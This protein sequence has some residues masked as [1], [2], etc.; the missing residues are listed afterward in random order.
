MVHKQLEQHPRQR[1]VLKLKILIVQESDWIKRNP[2]QQHHLMERMVLRGHEVKVI[3]YPIDWK[4]DKGVRHRRRVIKGYHKIHEGADVEVVRPAILAVPVLIYPSLYLSHKHEIERQIK[5]FKP[6]VIVGFGVV[7]TY[8]ASKIARK[9]RIPFVYYWIDVLHKLIPERGFHPLGKYMETVAIKNSQLVLTINQKLEEYVR[10]MGAVNTKVI[11]AGIDLEEFDPNLDGT[12][13]RREY[14]I[15]DEDTVLFFMGFL[16]HFAGL[17][18]LALEFA[19]AEHPNLKLLIVGDGDA[20]SDLQKIVEEN[21]LEDRVLLIGRK[22]YNEIP[23]FVAASNICILP[24]YPD[25]EI[26]QDIVPIKIYEYMAM[27]KPVI[28]TELPG[29]MAEFGN[30]NGITYV[31]K[32][33][34]VISR[35]FDIDVEVDGRK[36]RKLAEGNDWEGIVDEFERTLKQL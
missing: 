2:H 15:K 30:E 12:P 11:D 1:G 25:E 36:A 3:D 5:E 9:E 17:K 22:P 4:E 16:Y 28:T 32:P 24:A 20:Y 10:N 6:D 18:E 27:G 26:M 21:H 29:V 31:K 35:A 8:L 33:E 7:N 19:K 34:D 13:V 14:G 23:G